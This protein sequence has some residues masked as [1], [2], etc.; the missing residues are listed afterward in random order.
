MKHLII[1][2]TFIFALSG[3]VETII[4][5]AAKSVLGIGKTASQG[6]DVN[7]AGEAKN[8]AILGDKTEQEIKVKGNMTMHNEKR[9]G[10]QEFTGQVSSVKFSGVPWYF[11]LLF[12][13]CCPSPFAIY[14]KLRKRIRT[15]SK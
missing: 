14:D 10:G 5:M 12:G 11:I 15:A 7:M 9:E 6:I 4:P 3:C 1:I 8:Q 13:F 2:I